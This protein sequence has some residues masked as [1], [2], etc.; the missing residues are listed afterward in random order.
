MI[1]LFV[2]SSE[3]LLSQSVRMIHITRCIII[4]PCSNFNMERYNSLKDQRE[5]IEYVSNRLIERHVRNDKTFTRSWSKYLSCHCVVFDHIIVDFEL[6]YCGCT[7]LE[8]SY[9]CESVLLL[10]LVDR[11]LWLTVYATTRPSHGG[12]RHTQGQIPTSRLKLLEHSP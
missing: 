8:V 6:I 7:W 4:V 5:Q 1:S 11:L 12:L 9:S 10:S 2:N 3:W